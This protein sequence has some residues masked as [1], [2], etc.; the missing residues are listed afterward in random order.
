MLCNGYTLDIFGFRNFMLNKHTVGELFEKEK[1]NIQRLS[2]SI[3][4]DDISFIWDMDLK[5][6]TCFYEDHYE[7][8]NTYCKVNDCVLVYVSSHLRKV[9]ETFQT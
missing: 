8:V 6:I 5:R 1:E 9:Y 2:I 3:N 4:L 7:E